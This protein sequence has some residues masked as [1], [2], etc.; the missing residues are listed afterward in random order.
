MR[1]IRT[2]EQ[3]MGRSVRGEKDYSVILAIGPDIIRLLRDKGSRKFLSSQM[4]TQIE[5][6]LEI[7]EMA[8]QDIDAGTEPDKAFFGLIRQCLTR[9]PDWKA[10]YVEQMEKVSPTGANKRVL[11]LYAAELGAEQAFTSGDYGNAVSKL[12]AL[13]DGGG[14]DSDDKGWYLQEMARYNYRSNRPESQRLQ[15]AAHKT[16]RLLLKPALGVTVSQLTIVSQGRVQRIAK[17]VADFGSYSALDVGVSDILDRL[18]FGMKADKF[19]SAL[20]ELVEHWASLER[21]RT[22]NGKK[23]RIICGHWILPV[24]AL[25]M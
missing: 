17:W 25:G 8:K 4:A 5:I 7:T 19:E 13:L 20:D 15:I 22:K 6:G 2:V 23:V 24:I 16:N 3:G 10:F 1:T 9:D 14:I 21:G 11:D 18:V 12:Q